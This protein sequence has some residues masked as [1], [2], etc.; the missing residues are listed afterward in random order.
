MTQA[1]LSTWAMEDFMSGHQSILSFYLVSLSPLVTRRWPWPSCGW[2]V[3]G[4]LYAAHPYLLHHIFPF[5]LSRLHSRQSP[6]LLTMLRV[7]ACGAIIIS[8][9]IIIITLYYHYILLSHYL[10]LY[11]LTN[12]CRLQQ[13]GCYELH[14]WCSQTAPGTWLQGT[15]PTTMGSGC[16]MVRNVT[17]SV[18]V[19]HR[20]GARQHM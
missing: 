1:P 16:E 7:L 14:T 15:R 3:K 10:S 5:L 13:D 18:R 4:H 12:G 9:Y 19:S 2:G 17:A 11:Q 20:N 8:L 6:S